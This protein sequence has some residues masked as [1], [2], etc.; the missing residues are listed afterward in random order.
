MSVNC[1]LF[2][3]ND[4]IPSL[5]KSAGPFRLATELRS[6]GFSTQCVDIGP[7]RTVDKLDLYQKIIDKFVG[8]DTLWLGISTTFFEKI[9][10]IPIQRIS[11]QDDVISEKVFEL[12]FLKNILDM[13]REKNPKI[14]FIIGGGFYF[15]L[16]AYDFYHFRGNAD[17]EL[18]EFTKWCADDNYNPKIKRLGKIIECDKDYVN[19]HKSTIKWEKQDIIN[20]N[21]VLPIEIARGCIF[22]CKFCNF[23]LTGKTKGDW[24]KNYDV[25]LEE[26]I[27]NYENFGTTKYMFA[28]DTYNDSVEKITGL[29]ENVYSKLPFKLEFTTYLR[30]DLLHRFPHTAEILKESGL[31]ATMFGIETNNPVS[32]K[33]IGKGLDFNKQMDLLRELKQTHFKDIVTHSGFILGLPGD[34]IESMNNLNKTLMDP[35]QG[36]LDNWI[37]KALALNPKELSWQKQ[38][39]SVFDLEHE[40]YGYQMIEEDIYHPRIIKWKNNKNGLSYDICDDMI[41]NFN[42]D[43][44]TAQHY[45]IGGYVY[46]RLSNIIDGDELR[47]SSSI[48]IR[49]KYNVNNLTKIW[50]NNYY[51]SVLDI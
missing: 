27:Y 49:K 38:Y 47:S 32:A 12:G 46:S 50:I 34:T 36:A 16:H 19:F 8:K 30:L 48:D 22:K 6:A 43:I 45:K 11:L 10:G 51:R 14:K 3:G 17:R 20:P 21:D 31:K 44:D 4:V 1:L 5:L 37:F 26:L 18:V 9:L 2:F 13:C 29:Y 39:F 7:L 24:I 15:N 25:L 40:K 41:T 33:A 28:D 23:P 35:N 42:K